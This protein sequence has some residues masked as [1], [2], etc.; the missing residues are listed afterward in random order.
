LTKIYKEYTILIRNI[1]FFKSFHILLFDMDTQIKILKDV[2]IPK[3]GKN[4]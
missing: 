3:E 4:E 1:Y 2:Y